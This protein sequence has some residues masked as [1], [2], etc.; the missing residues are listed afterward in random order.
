MTFLK[1]DGNNS[2]YS[3]N[4]NRI[5]LNM[6]LGKIS[7]MVITNVFFLLDVQAL[8][9]QSYPLSCFEGLHSMGSSTRILMLHSL[10]NLGTITLEERTLIFA[11]CCLAHKQKANI[12]MMR[13]GTTLSLT[14]PKFCWFLMELTSLMPGQR[15]PMMTRVSMTQRK[16]KCLSIVS[17]KK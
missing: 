12:W 14:Q 17:T 1:I 8:V 4:R 2:E 16:W 11:N 5:S 7:L 9:K 3:Q 6:Y 10:W 15:S 13:S